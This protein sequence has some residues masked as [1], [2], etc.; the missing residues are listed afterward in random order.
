[1][2]TPD[3]IVLDEKGDQI[4]GD[5]STKNQDACWEKWGLQIPGSLFI[6]II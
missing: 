5:F 2:Y 1:M 4:L 3:S 6:L